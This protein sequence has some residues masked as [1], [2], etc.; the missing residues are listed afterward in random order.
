MSEENVEI[1]TRGIDAW[2]WGDLNEF[3]TGF[4]P[5][6]ELHT[7]GRF[8][9]QGVYRGH[10]GLK[11]YWAEIRE[12]MESSTSISDIRAV[13]EGRVFVAAVI[14]NRGRR[15]KARIEAPYWFVAT[16][17]D[18]LVVRLATYA[19]REQALEAAGLSE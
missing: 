15:S 14:A 4:A 1:V 12:D 11:R 16:F 19:G 10:A 2:N 5:D 7:T 17:R 8:A 3:L 9:D 13:G 6:A 18:G